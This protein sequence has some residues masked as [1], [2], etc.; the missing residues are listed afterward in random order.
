[1]SSTRKKDVEARPA[2]AVMVDLRKVLVVLLVGAAT[3]LLAIKY[4]LMIAPAAANEVEAACKGLRPAPVNKAYRTG[5][6]T[7]ALDFTATDFR[8]NKVRLSDYR[9]QVVFVNFWAS[10]CNVCKSEKPG[11]EDLQRSMAGE[12]FTV[13][14]LASDTQWSK[15]RATFPN[16]TPLEVLLDP[17]AEGE[18]LGKIAKSYGITAVP[19]SF[20]VDKQGKIRHYFINKRDWSSEVSHTCI[21]ALIDE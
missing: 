18:N 7:D 1:V 2:G 9:G 16:G 21:Q 3:L 8:G 20:L 15:I 11:L 17:P 14:A 13:L 12:N 10:W 4:V 6:P 5:F 19:E